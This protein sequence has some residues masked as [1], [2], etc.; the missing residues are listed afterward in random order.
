MHLLSDTPL[1]PSV[2]KLQEAKSMLHSNSSSS[3]VGRE[4]EMATL[5]LFLEE[6]LD[7]HQPGSLYISGPPGTGKTATV[8][9]L[10]E[11]SNV[12]GACVLIS[13]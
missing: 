1:A 3:L 4:E 10:L 5:R 11:E 12:G 13:L 8:T 6:H 2:S 7:H 9:R